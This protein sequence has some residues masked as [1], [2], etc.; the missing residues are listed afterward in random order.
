MSA[1]IL[2]EYKN[3]FRDDKSYLRFVRVLEDRLRDDFSPVFSDTE[4][5]GAFLSSDAAK[6]VIYDRLVQRMG[7][8][9]EL[10]DEL[11]RRIEDDKSVDLDEML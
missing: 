11:K 7:K 5:L 6:D 4:V 1:L 9:P 8:N 10:L 3:L 2:D